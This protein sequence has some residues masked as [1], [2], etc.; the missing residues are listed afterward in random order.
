[1]VPPHWQLDFAV[2]DTDATIEAA[3]GLGGGVMVEPIDV[4]AGRFAIL[5]DPH[6]AS[7]GVIALAEG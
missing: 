2:E 4:P 7:F 1:M 3:K 5:T 6:G